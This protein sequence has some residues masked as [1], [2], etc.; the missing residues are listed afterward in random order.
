MN[1]LNLIATIVPLLIVAVGLIGWV[2][3]LRGDLSTAQ[4]QVADLKG[5]MTPLQEEAKQSTIEINNLHQLIADLD[6][7]EEVIEQV[8]V[9]VFKG[10]ELSEE[11]DARG[12]EI[13][14]LRTGLALAN[15]QMRTIMADHS[16][17]N[18]VLQQLGQSGLLPAG[19]RRE[20]G[21]YSNYGK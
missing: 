8:D 18:D 6:R 14:D 21:G 16:G 11:L 10:E 3:T 2:T 7:I 17:F 20:Y 19:E 1:K 15:D 12:P 4:A 5:Q 9:I 13:D